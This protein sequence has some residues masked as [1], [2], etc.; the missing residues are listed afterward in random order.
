MTEITIK[1]A[2]LSKK[3]P[4]TWVNWFLGIDGEWDVREI[5]LFEVNNKVYLSWRVEGEKKERNRVNISDAQVSWDDSFGSL[6]LCA[7]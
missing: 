3:K 4:E 6:P 2:V 5:S 7:N 1:K